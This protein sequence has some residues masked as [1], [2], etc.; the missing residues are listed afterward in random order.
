MGLRRGG[1]A[2]SALKPTAGYGPRGLQF[3]QKDLLQKD[4]R[5]WSTPKQVTSTLPPGPVERQ[6]LTQIETSFA[7]P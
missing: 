6:N 1:V 7:S 5:A 4:L 3:F 2:L